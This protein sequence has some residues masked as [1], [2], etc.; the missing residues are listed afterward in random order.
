MAER[1]TR[2]RTAVEE[3]LAGA[4]DFR[5]AQQVH[6]ALVAAGEKVGLATVYRTLHAMAESG[7]VDVVRTP[8]GEASYRRCRTAGHHHHLVCRV[9]GR[10]KELTATVVEAWAAAIGAEHGFTDVT[11]DIELSGLCGGCTGG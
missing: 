2:Q 8:E 7:E 1:R 5:S 11:H 10:T 3:S 9:C 6:A 4:D